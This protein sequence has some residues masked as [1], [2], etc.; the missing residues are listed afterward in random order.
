MLRR[1][2][3]TINF[4][5]VVVLCVAM[6]A[7][8]VNIVF[9]VRVQAVSNPGD[10]IS[11]MFQCEQPLACMQA[12][13]CLSLNA[14]LMITLHAPDRR[15]HH[16]F[17]KA[18]SSEGAGRTST[19]LIRACIWEREV[20]TCVQYYSALHPAGMLA[21]TMTPLDHVAVTCTVARRAVLCCVMHSQTYSSWTT[22][23]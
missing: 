7:M 3:D 23:A 11:R 9:G 19:V 2:Q 21:W 14:C 10:A 17:N 13:L 6:T 20:V 18:T 1:V 5:I 15:I 12:C 8:M 4:V 16:C 22:A